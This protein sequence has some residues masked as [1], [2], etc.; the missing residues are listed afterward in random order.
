MAGAPGG[1]NPEEIAVPAH[2]MQDSSMKTETF[3]LAVP[4]ELAGEVRRAAKQT[5]LS[6]ADVMR[7]S[8]K[9]GLQLAR[10]H[11]KRM[12]KA[13]RR[14]CWEEPNAEFDALEHHCAGLSRLV[15]RSAHEYRE[16]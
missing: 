14:L 16:H 1:A 9:L 6:M 7:Q 12:S 4:E 8:M 11:V 13:E 3:P 5:N 10:D 15:A 2:F